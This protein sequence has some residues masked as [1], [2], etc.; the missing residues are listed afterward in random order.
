MESRW[1][2]LEGPVHYI[3]HGGRGPA[4]VL[5]H[6]LGGSHANWVSVAPELARNHHVYALD[7]IGFGRTPLLG[8]QPTIASNRALVTRFIREIAGG[9]A[10]LVGNS[11]GGTISIF[12]AAAEPDIVDRMVL[13]DAACPAPRRTSVDPGVLAAF[14]AF[15]IPFVGEMV[16]ESRA[17]RLTPEQQVRETL[18]LCTPDASRIS[19]EAVAAQVAVVTERRSRPGMDRAFLA[20]ARSLVMTLANPAAYHRQVARVKAPTLMIQG[21]LDRLVSP[22]SARLLAGSRPDWRF[23][24]LEGVGHVPM[25]EVPDLV[26][27]ILTPWLTEDEAAA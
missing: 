9:R 26:L 1:A 3:D 11:M 5:I 2:D 12:T 16:L 14:A 19:P 17:R 27:E 18:R 7:L 24:L 20:A 15:S 10:S 21:S 4:L 6:G 13:V 25:L 22:A 8:R 23:E